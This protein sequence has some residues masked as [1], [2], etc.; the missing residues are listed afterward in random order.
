MQII[1]EKLEIPVS[2]DFSEHI[3]ETLSRSYRPVIHQ[4]RGRLREQLGLDRIDS[5][6]FY[7]GE[8][9]F[10]NHGQLLYYQI[11]Q[12]FSGIEAG[13][14][15]EHEGEQT[16]SGFKEIITD[17]AENNAGPEPDWKPVE[18]MNSQFDLI[19]HDCEALNG[20]PQETDAAYMLK[21]EKMRRVLKQIHEKSPC[22]QDDLLKDENDFETVNIINS[23]ES[24]GLINKEFYIFCRKSGQQISKV[25]SLSAIEDARSHGFRCFACGNLL[26]EEKIS[27]QVRTSPLG[28]RFAQPNYWLALHV[29]KIIGEM[30]FAD[31]DI[32]VNTEKDNQVFD[33]FISSLKRFIM[34]EIRDTPPRLE[35][36]F[37]FLTRANFYKPFRAILVCSRPVGLDVKMY[38]ASFGNLPVSLVEG[39]D[40]LEK[41]L[42]S[43]YDQIKLDYLNAIFTEFRE[44]TSMSL[45]SFIIEKF[46]G[47]YE[48]PQEEEVRLGVMS[49]RPPMMTE[50][51]E[52]YGK[53]EEFTEVIPTE[54]L[55]YIEPSEEIPP[56]AMET[57]ELEPAIT[58][59]LTFPQDVPAME[60]DELT[61]MLETSQEDMQ[62]QL[63]EVGMTGEE[64]KL[65]Q[66]EE[67]ISGDFA[68]EFAE[69]L[70]EE[71]LPTDE[72]SI[73]QES[74][75][76]LLEKTARFILEF[77]HGEGVPGNIDRI[78][79]ELL[80]INEIGL[81]GGV[82][83]DHTGLVIANSLDINHDPEIIAGYGSAICQSI[84]D[85]LIEVGFESAS[86]VHLE[87]RL[88]RLKIFPGSGFFLIAHEDKK[89]GEF[90]DEG[91][92]L[93]GEMA[94]REAIMKK[95]LDDLSKTEGVSGN[96][97]AGMDGLVIETNLP[98]GIDNDS[99]GYI[100]SQFLGDNRRFMERLG[101]G[102][103]RQVMFKTGDSLYSLIP[104]EE[105]AILTTCL[106]PGAPREVW[107]SRLPQ[108]GQMLASVLSE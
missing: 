33:L 1:R 21:D 31:N 45:S 100:V 19:R 47:E 83:A 6:A 3:W 93:P 38:L 69:A 18:L 20:D 62:V 105:E 87:G 46:Y 86:W 34:V 98:D 26:S 51:E 106:N 50:E 8:I 2:R 61:L 80:T 107:Q 12:D 22:F 10:T 74:P 59:E 52:P 79:R 104:V 32:L 56:E 75:D 73:T 53:I 42:K 84:N 15:F 64:T 44:E 91:N 40:N 35:E 66:G 16:F 103:V 67:E 4:I 9:F 97:L 81:Y 92:T 76:E 102:P 37:M 27:P 24:L 63:E 5:R 77:T 99:L 101:L 65:S 48:E 29:A 88:G 28:G 94:L 89:A 36:I 70:P 95:V 57:T 25:N 68:M 71:I 96:L 55:A 54:E 43:S 41:I 78:E 17:L 90:D 11:G 30:G 23:L 7:G 13:T 60:G 39:T 14:L 58:T 85:L 108:A 72:L 82:L 49:T